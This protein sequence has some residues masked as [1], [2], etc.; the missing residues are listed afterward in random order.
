MKKKRRFVYFYEKRKAGRHTVAFLLP[1]AK[2]RLSLSA[3][4]KYSSLSYL[5][6]IGHRV[7]AGLQEGR[8]M[9]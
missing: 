2:G 8:G 4:F 9:L 7:E 6:G 1:N 5:S 3:F